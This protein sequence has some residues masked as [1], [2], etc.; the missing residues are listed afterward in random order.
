VNDFYNI[1][2]ERLTGENVHEFEITINPN[3]NVFKGH[4]PNQ[5][6]VPGV[7]SINIIK[8][9]FERIS[10]KPLRYYAIKQCKFLQPIIPQD[11]KTMRVEI[12]VQGAQTIYATIFENEKPVVKLRAEILN[13]ALIIP[14]YNNGKTIAQI[15]EDARPYI[16]NIIVVND[17]STDKTSEILQDTKNIVLL[18]HS[19]NKGKGVALRTAFRY[20]IQNGFSHAITID[21]DGQHKAADIPKFLDELATDNNTLLIGARN[22]H[23]ENMPGKNTF[24]NK[25]SNFW[26]WAETG[27]RMQDTQSGFRLYPL[28]PLQKMRFI[29]RH[30][31]FEVEA[32]VRLSW[33]GIALKNIPIEIIYP[34]KGERVSH[35]KPIKDFARISLLNTFLVLYA[36]LIA[37]P[38]RFFK[39]FSWKNFTN[40]SDSNIKITLSIGTGIAF[41]I[42]PFWG[43]Q[44]ILAGV[45]AV[46][47]KL[48]KL[49]TIAASNISIPPM[50]PIILYLSYVFGG[51]ILG[52]PITI[53]LSHIS[54]ATIG[55]A[56]LQYIVGSFILA[57]TA[58][59]VFGLAC[60]ITLAIFRKKR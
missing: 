16:D 9:L 19:T 44:M 28:K 25:F 14:T 20:A 10:G 27:V 1:T 30:Y 54:F 60:Y 51:L 17:G 43:Y 21:A 4:F 13:V 37:H 48:N 11:G 2:G 47:F 39:Q 46:V 12:K 18:Q 3:H 56:L 34:P 41:G 52:L 49:I 59:F 29:T 55:E 38:A 26:I 32:M 53:S 15:I 8:Q 23:A 6:I 31:D 7:F 24:A 57:G 22:L 36:I 33:K 5:P 42:L 35:F 40:I 50:I 58:G 45:T